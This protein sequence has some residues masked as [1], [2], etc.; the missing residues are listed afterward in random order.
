MKFNLTNKRGRKI[1]RKNYKTDRSFLQAVYRANEDILREKDISLTEFKDIITSY[2]KTRKMQGEPMTIKKALNEYAH[3]T[4]FTPRRNVFAENI[5]KGLVKH[6]SY[7]LF[8]ELTKD[9]NNRY[10]KIN[11]DLFRYDQKNNMYVYN[12]KIY[13]ILKNSP[14]SMEI[15]RL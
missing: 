8:R 2:V 5:V 4:V 14:E 7:Q 13:I 10:T 1:L 6:D 3:S 11:Y 15:G 12:E 9:A